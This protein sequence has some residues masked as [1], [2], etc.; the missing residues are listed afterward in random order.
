MYTV[1]CAKANLSSYK[2]WRSKNTSL[3]IPEDFLTP[4][5]EVLV[6]HSCEMMMVQSSITNPNKGQSEV[7][8][9]K[10]KVQKIDIPKSSESQAVT[11]SSFRRRQVW[12]PWSKDF[13]GDYSATLKNNP[14]SQIKHESIFT[15]NKW[16]VLKQRPSKD[17]HYRDRSKFIKQLWDL[18][19][20]V[21]V[22][23]M[24]RF[25][26]L[27]FYYRSTT[28]ELWFNLQGDQ[29]QLAPSRQQVLALEPQKAFRF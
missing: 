13:K 22:Q 24:Q 2:G 28:W 14:W 9:V 8:C 6:S 7:K 12:Q 3:A 16:Q 18:R 17:S 4:S 21:I 26:F 11:S 27:M 10:I 25:I 15:F 1:K 5:W 23:F 19:K 20:I 29:V